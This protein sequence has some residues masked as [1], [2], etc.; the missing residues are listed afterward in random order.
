MHGR[1]MQNISFL[2]QIAND[3]SRHSTKKGNPSWV[4]LVSENSQPLEY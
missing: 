2:V 1:K 3:L 4:R